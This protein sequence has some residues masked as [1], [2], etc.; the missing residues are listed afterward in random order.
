M[1]DD[2]KLLLGNYKYDI[3]NKQ[4]GKTVGGGVW[5]ERLM[6]SNNGGLAS[7]KVNLYSIDLV[8]KGIINK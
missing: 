3:A 1:K 6:L 4:S 7:K 2:S 8:I 5:T